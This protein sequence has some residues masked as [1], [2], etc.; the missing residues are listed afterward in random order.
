M[1]KEA[2]EGPINKEEKPKVPMG[3][4]EPGKPVVVPKDSMIPPI[5]E[6]KLSRAPKVIMDDEVFADKDL[7]PLTDG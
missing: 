3:L 6:T 5:H 1:C 2:D 7:S 4:P